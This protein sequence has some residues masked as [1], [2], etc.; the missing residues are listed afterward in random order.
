MKKNNSNKVKLG[1]S[2]K[3]VRGFGYVVITI[4]ALACI[5]PFL[6]ILGSSFTAEEVI[7]TDCVQL[8]PKQFTLAAYEMVCKGGGIWKSYLLTIILTVVGTAVGL[9]IIAMTGYALQR[10][11]FPFRNGIS[12]YIYFT[13]LFSAGHAPYYLLMTQT[14][15]LKDS[16]FAVL[17]PLMMSP[18][19]IIMMK[20]FV[21]AIPHEIT[22]S[23]KIDGAGDMKIFVSLILPMLKP[24]LATIGLFL[25][26]GYWNEWYQS[27]LF[28]SSK[29]DVKPLQ[30]TLYEV[31][32]KMDQL[33]NSIAGQYISLA[34]IPTEG[35]KMANAILATGPIIFL[36]PFVQKYFISGITVGAVKG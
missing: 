4:Y 9:T 13:R 24:A 25:A 32:N 33:K 31:V 20:N 11:D 3:I 22:E 1:A 12:F 27:S 6:L 29:V 19:L 34:D 16:Y 5:F 17:L 26:L 15:H 35:I 18:W 8:I 10:K 23:G 14:Y 2:D 21:K 28:L 30:Y 7:R 36:Y